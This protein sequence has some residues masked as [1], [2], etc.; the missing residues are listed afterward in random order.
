MRIS[1]WSS[2]VCSSDLIFGWFAAAGGK[3][4]SWSQDDD[5]KS[6]SIDGLTFWRCGPHPEH[7]IVID[8]L[9]AFRF[10]GRVLAVQNSVGGAT[11]ISAF[12]DTRRPSPKVSI[13]AI[14]EP[15]GAY[16]CSSEGR[17]LGKALINHGRT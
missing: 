14:V 16:G 10:R 13:D 11:G 3:I 15:R 1:D 6:A 17:R 5:A 2:D 12:Y 8:N 4:I 7:G 9:S